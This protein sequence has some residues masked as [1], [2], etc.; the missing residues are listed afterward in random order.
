[1]K[2]KKCSDFINEAWVEGQPSEAWEGALPDDYLYHSTERNC[3]NSIFSHGLN[4][5][6]YLTK[7][8]EEARQHHPIVL[9]ILADKDKALKQGNNYIMRNIPARDIVGIVK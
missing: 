7:T 6:I 2:I 9:K 5:K 8:P 4:G 3:L 1:M